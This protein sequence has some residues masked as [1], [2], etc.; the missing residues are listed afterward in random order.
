MFLGWGCYP[1]S[2]TIISEVISV[3]KFQKQINV[4]IA[5]S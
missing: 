2:V 1:E 3:L 4:D 5:N